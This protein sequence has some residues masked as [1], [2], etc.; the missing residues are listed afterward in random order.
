MG[1]YYAMFPAP[2]VTRAVTTFTAPGDVVLDPFSGRG[3][4][5]FVAAALGRPAV[6]VDI[7]PVA[8]LFTAAKLL[9]AQQPKR[10][11]ARVRAIER[12]VR[13]VDRRSRSRF[14]TMA[15]A[16]AVRGFLKAARRELDWRNSRVDRTLMAFVALHMQ[17]SY[18]KGLSNRFSPTVAHSASYAVR[19]WTA[20]GLLTPPATDPVAFLTDRIA[21]RYA[22]GLP[23]MAPSKPFLGDARL[24]LAQLTPCRAKLLITSPPYHDVT[25]Y[26]NDHWIRL[27]ILGEPLRKNW[28]RTQK[29]T[30]LKEYR[31]LMT[32]VFQ[33][34]KRHLRDDGVVLVRCGAKKR[35]A[36]T[37]E[38]AIREA[39]PTKRVLSGRT[40]VE[41]RG[42]ASGY[43]H[44][45]KVVEEIDIVA[46]PQEAADTVQGWTSGAES[47]YQKAS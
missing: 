10:V 24:K 13:P 44:G 37:C 3:N 17:D 47:T 36:E 32:T 41:R 21:R 14:E 6:A 26:W 38:Q 20:R 39:W 27:W 4:A 25:D 18:P 11:L 23:A 9:P 40:R 8:W 7:Q 46:A 30:N 33:R 43:G 35:T 16:P 31:S 12:A 45:A 42:V 5:P 2:F 19:W 34:A 28:R 22:F 1:R 29:H 15:W